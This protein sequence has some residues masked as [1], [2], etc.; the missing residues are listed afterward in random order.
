M[1]NNEEGGAA[2]RDGSSP[3]SAVVVNN[4]R[5][6][7]E[8]IAQRY[9]GA[10]IMQQRL[11]KIDGKPLDVLTVAVSGAARDVYFDISSF[12]GKGNQPG[13]PC[14]YCGAPLRTPAAKQC[15]QCG[16]DWHDPSN[17]IRR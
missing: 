13:P 2:S 17:V 9:A 12:F 15:R 3:E 4:V 14:P 11:I 5:E 1:P 6:E 8:W 10:V 16:T 7:R